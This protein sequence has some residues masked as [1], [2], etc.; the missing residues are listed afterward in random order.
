MIRPARAWLWTQKDPAEDAPPGE[1]WR[2]STHRDVYEGTV[3]SSASYFQIVRQP[4]RAHTQT[5]QTW[6]HVNRTTIHSAGML[7]VLFF[8]PL[9][10]YEIFHTKD[11]EKKRKH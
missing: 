10:I 7:T 11:S 9:H 8:L 6:Q 5:E 1:V 2:C 3:M 4:R